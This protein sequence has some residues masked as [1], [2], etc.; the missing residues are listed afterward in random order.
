VGKEVDLQD[1]MQK[2]IKSFIDFGLPKTPLS[3]TL[4]LWI[5]EKQ[6]KKPINNSVLVELFIEN[7]LEKTNI[8]NI[9]SETFDFTNKKRLLSFVSKY[10]HDN[11]DADYSYAVDYVDLLGYF[12][13]YLKTRFHGQPQKVLD[14]FIK[15]G[16]L[17]YHDDNLVRFKSAFYFHYFLALHFDYD[18]TFK[19]QVFTGENYLSFIEEITYYTGLKRDD[20]G[21]LNFTQEKLSEAFG[22]FNDDIRNNHEKVD[23]VLESKRDNTLP[24][25]LLGQG[26]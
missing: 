16:I 14:D 25:T 7:L 10:M 19:E 13:D 20:V 1:N 12:K 11:G 8:E 2:L 17:T 6:E 9:Y 23:K 24:P 3:V 5:F 15:R 4:F 22:D 21:V 18:P 26:S